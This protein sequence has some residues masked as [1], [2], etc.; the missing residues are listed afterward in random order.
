[1]R[2][3]TDKVLLPRPGQ[4]TSSL[5]EGGRG[6]YGQCSVVWC[7]ETSPAR[8]FLLPVLQLGWQICGAYALLA[9]VSVSF[10]IICFLLAILEITEI[11]VGIYCV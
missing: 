9:Q 10:H 2:G 6:D 5:E 8:S 3:E 11:Y 7:L 1:M 4:N